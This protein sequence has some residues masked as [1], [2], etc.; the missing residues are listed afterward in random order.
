MTVIVPFE[1]LTGSGRW[2]PYD[3]VFGTETGVWSVISS[4]RPPAGDRGIIYRYD[5]ILFCLRE[6]YSQHS[7]LIGYALRTRAAT[8]VL[9]MRMLYRK[10]ARKSACS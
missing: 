1:V 6:R 8:K 7:G 5:G 3:L 10:K 2:E 4:M 9:R